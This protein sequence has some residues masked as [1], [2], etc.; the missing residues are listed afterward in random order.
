MYIC[1]Y[2]YM[3]FFNFCIF[4]YFICI[5]VFS[6]LNETILVCLFYLLKHVEMFDIDSSLTPR[7]DDW[8]VRY[9][10]LICQLFVGC[11][12]MQFQMIFTSR[13]MHSLRKSL[14]FRLAGWSF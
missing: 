7:N 13:M 9:C 2:E 3:Y 12:C 5:H 8:T 4:E 1:I 10:G 6:F 14:F 11:N